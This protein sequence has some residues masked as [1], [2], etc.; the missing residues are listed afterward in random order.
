MENKAVKAYCTK[1]NYSFIWIE[2]RQ[3]FQQGKQLS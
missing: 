2:C 1:H 3:A